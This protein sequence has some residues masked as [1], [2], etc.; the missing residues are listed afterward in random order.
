[1]ETDNMEKNNKE[2]KA[3][4]QMMGSVDWLLQSLIGLVD[5]C[6]AMGIRIVLNVGGLL[7]S[8]ELIGIK[9]YLEG[10][11][12]DLVNESKTTKKLFKDL[13]D[14]IYSDLKKKPRQDLEK[15]HFIHLRNAKFYYPGQQPIPT[16]QGIWWRGRVEAIDAF[17]LGC[18]QVKSE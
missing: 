10:F 17:S 8:G 7:V 9:R 15:I 12:E 14:K 11:G 16:N 3:R 4:K 2:T 5:T 18:F 13:G 1:M 6:D